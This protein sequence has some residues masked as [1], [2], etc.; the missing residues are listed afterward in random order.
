MALDKITSDSLAAGAVNVSA[1]PDGVISAA[2]LHTT[3]ISDK[4]GYTPVSPTDLSSGL[5]LKANASALTNV[6]NKSSA[7]IRSEI[8]SSNVI[9]ALG[10][11]PMN[12]ASPIFGYST[13]AWQ[14]LDTTQ[15]G[16]YAITRK[17]KEFG[18][19]TLDVCKFRINY[20]WGSYFF[21]MTTLEWG[22]LGGTMRQS[23]VNQIGGTS[24]V[25]GSYAPY[26]NYIGT[27]N[28]QHTHAYYSP[29]QTGGGTDVGWYDVIPR[30]V[31]PAYTSVQVVIEFGLLSEVSSITAKGQIQFY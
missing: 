30:V 18:T 1:L 6:E 3:A 31:V 20:G 7:T 19:G 17:V 15:Y 14:L 24:V 5:A 9:T 10:F 23:S 25:A 12:Q 13:T 22:Y 21:R 2:K 4:L 29:G 16:Q 8:S 26:W 11:T 27:S 28:S